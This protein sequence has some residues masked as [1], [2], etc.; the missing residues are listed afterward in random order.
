MPR[1]PF[2][3]FKLRAAFLQPDDPDFHVAD[4]EAAVVVDEQCG[5]RGP[6]SLVR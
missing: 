5:D 4:A 3:F 2:L 6:G 1:M